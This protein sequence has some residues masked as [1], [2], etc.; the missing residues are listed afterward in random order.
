MA[1]VETTARIHFTATLTLSEVEC[2]AL[3][4]LVGYG[5]DAFLK[6]FREKLGEAYIR[7][8]EDGLRSAFSA[9]RRDVVGALHV[10]DQAR[11]DLIE[12]E[13]RRR[14]EEAA[15]NQEPRS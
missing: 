11:K 12:A 4:A 10:I 5:D 8:H 13:K 9:I 3:D 14:T 6:V 7:Q 15:L 1:T 2:R